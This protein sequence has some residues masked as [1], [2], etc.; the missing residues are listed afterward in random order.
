MKYTITENLD[1]NTPGYV[2]SF[3]VKVTGLFRNKAW[4]DIE[5]IS[6]TYHNYVAGTV[7]RDRNRL[8]T[9]GNAIRNL[10]GITGFATDVTDYQSEGPMFVQVGSYE[11]PNYNTYYKAVLGCGYNNVIYYNQKVT[12][13][14]IITQAN[15]NMFL[16]DDTLIVIPINGY[17]L[18]FT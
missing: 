7:Y 5:L 6:Y 18:H 10:V 2:I 16:T 17:T 9:I 8:E 1:S 4:N 14:G 13:H 15:S 11:D 3:F 12:I